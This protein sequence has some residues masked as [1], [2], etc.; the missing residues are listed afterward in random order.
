[1]SVSGECCKKHWNKGSLVQ[2]RLMLIW[3]FYII[4]KFSR[5]T[6]L[7]NHPYSKFFWSGFSRIR[8]H[9]D[10]SLSDRFPLTNF[11][12]VFS[13]ISVVTTVSWCKVPESTE[14]KGTLIRNVFTRVWFCY[15]VTLSR[16]C[17]QISLPI[18]IKFKRINEFLFPMKSSEN[19]RFSDGLKGNGS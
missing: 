3:S 9:S 19:L 1:M 11:L 10:F 13:I 17:H 8:T 18:L 16:D 2:N 4:V 15:F 7:E 6:L 12:P 5:N 14:I